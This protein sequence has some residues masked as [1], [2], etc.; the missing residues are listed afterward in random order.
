MPQPVEAS[1]SVAE[2]N[3]KRAACAPPDA[4]DFE[5]ATRGRLA[6]PPLS[7][8]PSRAPGGR[9]VWDFTGHAFLHRRDTPPPSVN[10][11][12]WRRSRLAAITSLFLVACTPEHALA[13]YREATGSRK[14]VIGAIRA[15]S[16][17]TRRICGRIRRPRRAAG[18]WR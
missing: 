10:P 7:A 12:L 1:S 17:A 4:D 6:I 8:I 13:L 16:T 2:A 5:D 18:T 11:H 14:P 3:R 9:P 15:G